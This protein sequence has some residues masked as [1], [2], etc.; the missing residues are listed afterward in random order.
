MVIARVNAIIDR[1]VALRRRRRSSAARTAE[2]K[3]LSGI[4]ISMLRVGSLD[5]GAPNF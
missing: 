2:R 1:V 3:P 4:T 5:N